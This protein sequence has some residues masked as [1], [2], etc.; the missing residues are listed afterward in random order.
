MEYR[1]E[2]LS[3]LK[4]KG[5]RPGT[6]IYTELYLD[7]FFSFLWRQ[8]IKQIQNITADIMEQYQR[9]IFSLTSQ[10]T[11]KKLT[12]RTIFTR[13]NVIK[14]YF[15]YL[16]AYGHLLIDPAGNISLPAIPASLPKNILQEEELTLLLSQPNVKTNI[17]LRDR[18]ILE[19]FYSTGIR[20]QELINLNL[21]DIDLTQRIIR[22]NKG[23][24]QKDRVIPIGKLSALSLEKYLSRVRSQW[25]R[26]SLESALFVTSQG[27]RLK[28]QTLNYTV[29]KYARKLY[30]DK[31]VSCHSLRHSCATHLLKGGA[32]LRVIQELLGHS[33]LNSTQVY[34]R[35]SPI[36]LKAAHRKYHP[37]G[38]GQ[39]ATKIGGSSEAEEKP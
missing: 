19:L 27:N 18:A 34:T 3:Y 9:H 30:P 37:R 33:S 31:K 10:Q 7:H 13:L 12:A 11:K 16:T 6:L 38:K 21:Y 14:K 2:F 25:S 35:V 32:S 39:P 29:K 5:Y 4:A 23:K 36:D 22:I 15:Q 28:P 26:S 8:G 24:R 17:G 1:N 20:R